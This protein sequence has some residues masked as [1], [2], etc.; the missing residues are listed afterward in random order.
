MRNSCPVCGEIE[1]FVA[2]RKSWKCNVCGFV[3]YSY[4][5]NGIVFDLKQ[6]AKEY[7]IMIEKRL[8]ARMECINQELNEVTDL[9][10]RIK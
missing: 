1:K 7:K 5:E 2:E 6:K 9:L 10:G 3:A 8:K 4:S